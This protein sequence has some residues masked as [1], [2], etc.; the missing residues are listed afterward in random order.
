MEMIPK[1]HHMPLTNGT[2]D[3]FDNL[4]SHGITVYC[5]SLWIAGLRAAAKIAEILGHDISNDWLALAEQANQQLHQALWDGENA[6]FHFFSYPFI[7]DHVQ[8]EELLRQRLGGEVVLGEDCIQSINDFVY[9]RGSVGEMRNSKIEDLLLKVGVSLQGTAFRMEKLVRKAY[10][11]LLAGDALTPEALLTLEK[12][13]DDSFGDPLLADTYLEMMGLPTVSSVAER[14]SVAQK[15]FAT[16]YKL[17]SPHCGYANLVTYD[18]QPK[19]AF[20]AQDVWIGVQHSNAASLLLRAEK[21][22]FLE[23]MSCLY[24]NLYQKAKIPFAAP[25]GF[26]CSCVLTEEIL[27]ESVG[28]HAQALLPQLQNLGWVL[29]DGRVSS[30]FPSE[31]SLFCKGLKDQ[32]YLDGVDMG[33]VYRTIQTTGLKYT[34]GRYFRPGM[35]FALPMLME[36]MAVEA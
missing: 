1:G 30:L 27:S 16:N 4:C 6:Y 15:A 29:R 32:A 11:L 18:G 17:N 8:D 10:V 36:Q 19:E 28:S 34:A 25:E 13:S 26:N 22:Q 2:D 31:E 3:T 23:L 21:G 20:Q 35:I 5:G 12:E 14:T 33:G 9:A 24:E 7:W